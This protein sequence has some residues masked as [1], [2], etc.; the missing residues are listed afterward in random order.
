MSDWKK[1]LAATAPD[2]ARFIGGPLGGVATQFLVDQFLPEEAAAAVRD[3]TNPLTSEKA[4][5]GA[6]ATASPETL[7]KLKE[8]AADFKVKMKDLEIKESALYI[9][10]TKDARTLA[11]QTS[12][13]PQLSITALFI[14]GYFGIVSGVIFTELT[15][16]NEVILLLGVMTSAIPQILS[17]WFGTSKGSQDKNNFQ[18]VQNELAQYKGTKIKELG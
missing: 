3:S 4:L 17:F 7:V 13:A 8:V 16:S 5:S 1:V 6:L 18:G 14:L 11:K 2:L 15:L 9:E 12:M 10:D